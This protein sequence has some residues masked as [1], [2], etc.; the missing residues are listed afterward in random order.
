[1]RLTAYRTVP[2]P[3]RIR[4]APAA[5]EWMDATEQRFAYRCLPLTIANTHG[6]EL[7]CPSAIEVYWNGGHRAKDLRVVPAGDLAGAP[8]PFAMSHFGA[9]VLT[10][11]T[12]YLFRTEPGYSLYVCGPVNTPRD[13][14]VPLSG[15]VETDWLP[16]PFTMNWLFTAPGGPLVFEKDEPFCHVFPVRR[17]LLE[18]VEPEIRD[19]ASEPELHARYL[20]WT[21]SRAAFNH[22]LKVRGSEAQ[23]E[24][25]QKHYAR[26]SHP[27]GTPGTDQ[28]RT[29]L[30]PRE[31][32]ER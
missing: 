21:T 29:R 22:D 9:G 18:E 10:F 7:L 23:A 8:P 26:G 17:D 6:W 24:K 13:G 19:L 27:D 15:I 3:T 25:W 5:R 32:V 30:R 11:D 2:E 12:G 20:E 14:A 31:F 4:A 16:Q 28:H 1:M